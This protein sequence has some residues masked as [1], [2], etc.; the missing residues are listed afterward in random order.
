MQKP[1]NILDTTWRN[2]PTIDVGLVRNIPFAAD[3]E[4]VGPVPVP[5]SL[6]GYISDYPAVLICSMSDGS[7]RLITIANRAP[8][9]DLVSE[10]DMVD[11]PITPAPAP[12][13]T[14]EQQP[15]S[16]LF[17]FANWNDNL[18][19]YPFEPIL[20]EL[21]F[22]SYNYDPEYGD[23]HWSVALFAEGVQLTGRSWIIQGDSF[24]SA[25]LDSL[26]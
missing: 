11:C 24:G 18:S 16:V 21:K 5:G 25:L 3:P 7:K 12:N 10:A 23:A 15:D 6:R 2:Q 4:P 9:G 8:S 17:N 14:T 20:A 22:T 26:I 13:G 1:L 19:N